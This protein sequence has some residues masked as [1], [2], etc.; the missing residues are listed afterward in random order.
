MN[1]EDLYIRGDTLVIH[2]HMIWA[3]KKKE[4]ENLCVS[5]VQGFFTYIG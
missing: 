3:T 4:M 2:T 1:R 5:V